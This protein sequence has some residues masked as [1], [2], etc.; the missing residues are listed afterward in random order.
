[1]KKNSFKV[2]LL[3][4][5]TIWIAHFLYFKRFG[6][7]EDDYANLPSHFDENFLEIKSFVLSWKFYVDCK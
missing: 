2:F 4:A 3:L 7:Y 6:L 1:M 5:V